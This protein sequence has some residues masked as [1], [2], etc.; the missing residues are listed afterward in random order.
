MLRNRSDVATSGSSWRDCYCTL[1]TIVIGHVWHD[2]LCFFLLEKNGITI[3]DPA[4]IK[5]RTSASEDS[6][7]CASPKAYF[8]APKW[9]TGRME[10]QTKGQVLK[11]ETKIEDACTDK[12]P[13]LE[14][15]TRT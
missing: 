1:G 4:H 14:R 10:Q 7:S 11:V 5:Q 15:A 12:R 6:C 8:P 3:A 2:V 13:F 9:A